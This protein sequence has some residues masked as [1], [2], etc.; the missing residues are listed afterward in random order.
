MYIIQLINK[1]TYK[2][3]KQL[4]NI[5]IYQNNSNSKFINN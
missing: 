1:Q 3:L 4:P 2:K 5:Y